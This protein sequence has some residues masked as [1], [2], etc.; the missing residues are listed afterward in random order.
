MISYRCLGPNLLNHCIQTNKIKN[1]NVIYNELPY[2]RWECVLSFMVND[3]LNTF[4][5]TSIRK[6]KAFLLLIKDIED[7]LC[8]IAKN[9][10]N[11]E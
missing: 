2:D 9:K 11:G 5:Y 10:Y 8:K 4:T 7:I 1:V 6:R 3:K